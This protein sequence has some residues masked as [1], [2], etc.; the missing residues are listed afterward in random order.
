MR[1]LDSNNFDD[2]ANV[3]I[4]KDEK[5]VTDDFESR[6]YTSSN[7]EDQKKE[8]NEF[9]KNVSKKNIVNDFDEKKNEQRV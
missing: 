7:E 2:E 6:A 8:K 4:S 5:E 9:E 3:Y 1:V